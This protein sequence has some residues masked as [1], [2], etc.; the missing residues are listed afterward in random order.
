MNTH[1]SAFPPPEFETP[2]EIV[3]LTED[4]ATLELLFQFMY[5]QHPPE[6]KNVDFVTVMS[7]AEAA[8]KYEVFF[9]IFACKTFIR[10]TLHRFLRCLM[11]FSLVIDP[12]FRTT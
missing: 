3:W 2:D 6:L 7:L 12:S 1:G 8:E 4:S 9:A 11:L 5:P 10:Y